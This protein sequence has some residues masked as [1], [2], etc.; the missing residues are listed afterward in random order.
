M[1]RGKGRQVSSPAAGAVL[2]PLTQTHERALVQA[3]VA[4]LPLIGS[5]TRGLQ[6]LFVA[7]RGTTGA[8]QVLLHAFSVVAIVSVVQ[9]IMMFVQPA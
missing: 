6:F 1:R 5:I 7:R 2:P 8:H 4:T 9:T 3:G